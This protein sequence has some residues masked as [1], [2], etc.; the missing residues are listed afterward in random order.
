LDIGSGI[1]GS[2][3]V[4]RYGKAFPN[5]KIVYVDSVPYLLEKL[6]K[7]NKV[8]ANGAQMPFPDESFDIAYAGHIISEGVLRNRWHSKDASYKIAREGHRILK[9]NG[10]FVFTY[11]MGDDN[12]TLDNLSEIGFREL[13]HLQ[14]IK[15]Y[16]IPTDTYAVRK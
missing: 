3:F 8:C 1:Y 4:N 14:R 6:D 5:T 12:Q 10:L 15:W 2:D 7:P 9:P 16:G 11:T 13:E